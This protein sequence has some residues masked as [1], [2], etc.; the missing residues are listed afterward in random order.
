[1]TAETEQE[2]S[3]RRY[4][5]MLFDDVAEL[6]EASRL[7][8]PG[9]IVDFAIATAAAGAG[10]DVLEIGCGTGQL[11]ERLAGYEF[12][13]TAIDIG[14][15]M[16]AAARRRIGDSAVSFQVASFEDLAA[17]D[18]S[19]DLII[20]ATAWHW[21]DPEV[22]FRKAARLL[23][24]GGWLAL[25]ATGEHYNGQ[26]GAAL[27][28]M[29]TARSGDRAAWLRQPRLDDTELIAATHL[30]EPAVHRTHAQQLIRPAD[31]VIAV[32]N[33]RATSLSWPG[34]E[35]QEF[36]TELRRQ[37]GPETAVHL[38]QMTTL[39]MARVLPGAAAS[40]RSAQPI[41]G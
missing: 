7:G 38:T 41:G 29:W 16:V 37:L 32:E 39:S 24:P 35:R 18:A 6:Y 14:A 36:S 21:I 22:R 10:S 19:L 17:A 25:L 28:D 11:T 26:F 12:R 30:F 4:Q 23:R 33:T 13:L 15:A 20:C 1:M 8:Y 5:R 27:L 31:A 3:K 2:R 9:E 34:G 40:G